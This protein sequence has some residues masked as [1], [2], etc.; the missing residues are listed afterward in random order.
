MDPLVLEMMGALAGARALLRQDMERLARKGS[1]DE[2][3][4]AELA[5][6]ARGCLEQSHSLLVI[7]L[8]QKAPDDLVE[9]IEGLVAFF[10]DV[11]QQISA[12]R[13]PT[14]RVN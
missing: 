1:A 14:K 6:R 10:S 7:V 8:F 11:G 3:T 5:A 4:L 9:T 13:S 12:M 2:A